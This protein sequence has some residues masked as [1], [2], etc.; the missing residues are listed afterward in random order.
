MRQRK[1][2]G[3]GTSRNVRGRMA[4]ALAACASALAMA[5]AAAAATADAD[6]T[7]QGV[8]ATGAVGEVVVTAPR[9]E[10]K[11]RAMQQAAPNIVRI[12]PA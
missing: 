7:D 2:H 8:A 1:R 3:A 6:S 9:E 4:V 5:S 11:A 12:Q 10:V